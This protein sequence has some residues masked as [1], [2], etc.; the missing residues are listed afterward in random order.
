MYLYGGSVPSTRQV[1]RR[2]FD[3]CPGRPPPF[4]NLVHLR[5]CQSHCIARHLNRPATV[6]PK[7]VQQLLVDWI[8]DT[9]GYSGSASAEHGSCPGRPFD[10]P[11]DFL[12]RQSHDLDRL[13]LEI[14]CHRV[15]CRCKWLFPQCGHLSN[16]IRIPPLYL[17]GSLPR[18]PSS[19]HVPGNKER[20]ERD[21]HSGCLHYRIACWGANTV[22]VARDE[23]GER[24]PGLCSI[25]HQR[26]ELA[27]PTKWVSRSDTTLSQCIRDVH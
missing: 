17:G 10:S 7:H 8:N 6:S 2:R 26:V 5:Q 14:L 25:S 24:R 20:G 16:L 3:V 19:V 1:S 15:Q 4:L 21:G 22:A 23:P 27:E 18:L 11:E 9:P 12:P 13:Q